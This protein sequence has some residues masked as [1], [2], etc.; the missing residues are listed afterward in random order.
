MAKPVEEVISSRIYMVE[1]RMTCG[2]T[3]RVL[4]ELDLDI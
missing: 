4:L 2:C 3:F 1:S